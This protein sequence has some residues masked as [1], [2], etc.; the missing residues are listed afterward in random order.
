MK[1]VDILEIGN[2]VNVRNIARMTKGKGPIFTVVS[3]EFKRK[4]IISKHE[5]L[6]LIN[7]LIQ[8]ECPQ[9][10]AMHFVRHKHSLHFA[11]SSRDDLTGIP[12]D[13]ERI[14][15][16]AF[17]ANPVG[18]MDM[19]EK[20][21]CRQASV[22][23]QEVMHLIVEQIRI[24]EPFLADRLQPACVARGYCPEQFQPCGYDYSYAYKERR[25]K[26]LQSG[27]ISQYKHTL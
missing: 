2:W 11:Q 27:D 12:R 15:H 17:M 10:V 25:E 14:I 16:Y 19:A 24:T 26:Y 22:E 13:P 18:L 4:M 20:R 1:I 7:Y 6:K 21:L 9:W 23:T 8:V 5:P 3:E